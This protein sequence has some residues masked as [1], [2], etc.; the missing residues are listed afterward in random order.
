M[1]AETHSVLVV[2]G[3]VALWPRSTL[4][5]GCLLCAAGC[6][7]G[8]LSQLDMVCCGRGCSRSG[9]RNWKAS[10]KGPWTG[11]SD[12]QG[13]S[14]LC[15]LPPS[16]WLLGQLLI[17]KVRVIA[18]SHGSQWLCPALLPFFHIFSH[19]TY[20]SPPISS[21]LFSHSHFA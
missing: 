5:A 9:S 2:F 18:A 6:I 12:L 11:S 17:F 15:R 8:F 3:Y 7:A 4:D 19:L 10:A 14:Y 1:A 16:C 13:Q 20:L 21:F